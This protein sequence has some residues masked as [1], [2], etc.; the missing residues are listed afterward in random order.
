MY[1]RLDIEKHD[2]GARG[3]EVGVDVGDGKIWGPPIDYTWKIMCCIEQ[4][5]I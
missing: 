4:G 5:S 2:C 3:L 1:V